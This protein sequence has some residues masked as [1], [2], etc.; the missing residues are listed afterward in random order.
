MPVQC[1]VADVGGPAL[2]PLHADGPLAHVKVPVDVL[3]VP[4]LLPVELLG[5]V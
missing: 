3:L 2:E 4:L 1:I 5:H